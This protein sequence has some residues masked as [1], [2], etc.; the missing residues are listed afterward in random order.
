MN[1]F[2]W[3]IVAWVATVVVWAQTPPS[4]EVEIFGQKIHYLEIG[5]GPTVI[6]LHGLGG[7]KTNWAFTA[8]ALAKN[9]HVYVPDQIGFGESDKPL[10][11]YRVGTLVDFLDGFYKKLGI[12]KATVVGNS[13]GGWTAAAFTLAHPD[14]VDRLV[15]VDSAGY[16]L[17]KTGLQAP[18]E[19]LLALNPATVEGEKTLMKTILANKAMVTDAFAENAFAAHMRKNDGYTI[20]R[21]LDS[22]LRNEDVIDGKLGT[23][24]VPTLVVWG[25]EDGLIPLAAGQMMGNEIEGAQTV[26][27]DHCGHVPQIE[28]AVPFNT[29][30]L[31]FLVSGAGQSTAANQ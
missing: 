12:T 8:P 6:L 4:K 10:I 25:R 18:R 28:C 13:L 19:L 31:K 14:K 16:S 20:D 5:S 26:I 23:I 17:A 2:G 27:L 30:L 29:T 1:R 7:D 22:I 9:Y 3:M 11:D 15:L 21:F 24:K